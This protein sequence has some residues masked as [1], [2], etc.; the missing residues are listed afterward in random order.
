M[1]KRYLLICITLMIVSCNTSDK[2]LEEEAV[3]Y[4]KVNQYIHLV[5]NSELDKQVVAEEI[6]FE[7]IEYHFSTTGKVR[8]PVEKYAKITAPFEGRTV[9]NYVSLGQ[10]IEKD[11]PIFELSSSSF[12][13]SQKERSEEHTSELQS[14][15]HLVCRLLLDRKKCRAHNKDLTNYIRQCRVY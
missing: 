8:P 4:K 12:F 3:M 14:R 11:D 10:K 2:N 6:A 15:G 5:S 13:E 9:K 1:F 7:D